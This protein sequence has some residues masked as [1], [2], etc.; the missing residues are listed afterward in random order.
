MGI[1]YLLIY[2]IGLFFLTMMSAACTPFK[3]PAS[4]EI[5]TIKVELLHKPRTAIKTPVLFPPANTEKTPIALQEGVGQTTPIR[6]DN[7][8]QP[9]ELTGIYHTGEFVPPPLHP[10]QSPEIRF[11]TIPEPSESTELEQD[12]TPEQKSETTAF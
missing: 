5:K 2:S 10:S 8:P 1:K 6:Q 12:A 7:P 11:H 3:Q 9:D 4:A